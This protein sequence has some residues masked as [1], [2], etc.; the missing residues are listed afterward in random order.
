[1]PVLRPAQASAIPQEQAIG[2]DVREAVLQHQPEACRSAGVWHLERS[3]EHRPA[4]DRRGPAM[5]SLPEPVS[6]SERAR[7]SDPKSAQAAFVPA[8]VKPGAEAAGSVLRVWSEAAVAELPAW[9]PEQREPAAPMQVAGAEVA[10]A[11]AAAEPPPEAVPSVQ[12][13][14]EAAGVPDAS[15]AAGVAASDVTVQGAAEVAR[16]GAEA[17]QLRVAARSDAGEA[18]AVLQRA[19]AAERG[20]WPRA[21]AVPQ[22]PSAAASV[23][24]QGRLRLPARPA[25][26]RWALR[27][28]V[29]MM[30]SLRM[31]SR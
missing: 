17:A 13:Q 29:H 30:R 6:A 4:A 27:C 12:R 10:S 7:H 22:V 14:A 24:R 16:P 31:A 23:F 3:S 2:Q 18:A 19:V 15:R 28:F 1:M 11:H 26:S 9:A 20:A 8:A 21:A 5:A 25:R